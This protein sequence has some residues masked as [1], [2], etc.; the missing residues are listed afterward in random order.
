VGADEKTL[1]L[2]VKFVKITHQFNLFDFN[3]M[4][5]K[6]RFT[7]EDKL[8]L[9]IKCHEGKQHMKAKDDWK[10]IDTLQDIRERLESIERRLTN[11]PHTNNGQRKRTS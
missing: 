7:Q 11:K 1:L 5:P 8:Y 6:I 10:T 9:R 3:E 2:M 4:R